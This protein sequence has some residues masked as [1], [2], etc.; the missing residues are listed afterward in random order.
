MN[1]IKV[2]LGVVLCLLLLWGCSSKKGSTIVLLPDSD[3]TVGKVEVKNKLGSVLI[4]N[5]YEAASVNM[6][7][8]PEVK[9]VLTK[10]DIQDIFKDALT[11]EPMTPSKF[12]LYFNVGAHKIMK[13]SEPIIQLI[14]ADIKK[15]ANPLISILGFTDRTGNAASNLKLS[16]KRA[17]QVKDTLVQS[18]ISQDIIEMVA[19]GEN[20]PFAQKVDESAKHLNRRVEVFVR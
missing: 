9:G 18:G 6:G 20:L 11:S 12:T 17:T 10:N 19:H 7:E 3:G 8:K 5:E 4:E 2:V 1:H 15:R 13:E 14:V 16:K